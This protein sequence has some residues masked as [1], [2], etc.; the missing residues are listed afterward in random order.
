MLPGDAVR[1]PIDQYLGKKHL[2]SW[3]QHLLGSIEGQLQLATG[4]VLLLGFSI[5]SLGTL[6]ITHQ[7]LVRDLE[8]DAT[9]IKHV[10]TSEASAAVELPTLERNRR[11]LQARERQTN[12]KHTVW[13]ELSDGT[14]L[15]PSH[16]EGS[17]PPDLIW[18]L[19]RDNSYQ[20]SENIR[21]TQLSD[22]TTILSLSQETTLP[23][24]RIGVA[25]NITAYSRA[26]NHQVS[27][28][29]V[30]WG[31]AMLLSLQAISLLVKKIVKPLKQLSMAAA[32][33][34]SE[35]LPQGQILLDKPPLEVADLATSYNELMGRLSQAWNQQQSFV[36]SVSHELRTPLTIISGYLERTLRRSKSLLPNERQDLAIA[37]DE[38]NRIK[39]LLTD[40]LILS[41]SDCS[42]LDLVLQLVNPLELLQD[43]VDQSSQSLGRAVNL[44]IKFSKE[45][46]QKELWTS[47]DQL[48]QVLLNLIENA[49][50]YSPN[51][52]P[53][54]VEVTSSK[55][56]CIIR[57]KDYGY[58]IPPDEL[59]RI[60]ERFY[61]GSNSNRREGS[62]L[63]LSVVKLLVDAM[64]GSI[65]VE[66]KPG[67][68]SCFSLYLPLK[69]PT[70]HELS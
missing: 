34:N 2:A 20:D 49:N 54:E 23:G 42:Q 17:V 21:E 15:L 27:L 70:K 14:D 61:R 19:L 50:K 9:T 25:Q 53:I 52:S 67:K 7:N 37:A 11:L 18:Q 45:L 32:N 68:G 47:A 16:S 63:G 6:T 56:E 40:L 65:Q 66:S 31:G 26:I 69:N 13:I 22:G 30:T 38:A 58:G 62:G 29:A 41:R 59:D 8:A 60:F 57:V 51:N 1:I 44:A 64:G 39:R 5:A 36:S 28:L 24:L 33:V 12:W 10:I 35:T 3:R 43:V 46:N 55:N 4:S 48:K